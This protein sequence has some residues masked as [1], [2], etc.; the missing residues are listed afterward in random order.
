MTAAPPPT[1]SRLALVG[2]VAGCTVIWSALFTVGSVLYGQ[3]AQ[4]GLL[5]VVFLVGGV[6]LLQVVRRL[7]SSGDRQ[8]TLV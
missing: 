6:V 3:L 2:W 8:E 1:T 4:A 7:W 5:F